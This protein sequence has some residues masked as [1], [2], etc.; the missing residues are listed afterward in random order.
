MEYDENFI[1]NNEC[2]SSI[3]NAKLLRILY[4]ANDNILN[5]IEYYENFFENNT[6]YKIT[7]TKEHIE[8]YFNELQKSLNKLRTLDIN[9]GVLIDN[10][11]DTMRVLH[12][13]SNLGQT[14]LDKIR[15]GTTDGRALRNYYSNRKSS[16]G[17]NNLKQTHDLEYNNKPITIENFDINNIYNLPRIKE[18][19]PVFIEIDIGKLSSYNEIKTYAFDM[20]DDLHTYSK[21]IDN[22]F[23]L[24]PI[25][26]YADNLYRLQQIIQ[27]FIDDNI[28]HEYIHDILKIL[29][30]LETMCYH[31]ILDIEDG[32][33]IVND[34]D[35][36]DAEYVDA[37]YIEYVDD[38]E[39]VEYVDDVEYVE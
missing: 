7:I 13:L 1:I 38:A 16:I 31:R 21:S 15:N 23:D 32:L 10:I 17:H 33:S 39:Y 19:K 6:F 3:H 14:N 2:E 27:K 20:V 29:D 5:K 24:N 11:L 26:K 36:I 22:Q 9:E 12:Y 34:D 37:E 35:N 18:K 28:C 8:S 25:Q 4:E 30:G